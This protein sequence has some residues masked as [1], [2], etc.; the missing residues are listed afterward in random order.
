MK[1]ADQQAEQIAD[2]AATKAYNLTRA[3]KRYPMSSLYDDVYQLMLETHLPNSGI[4]E[5][6]VENAVHRAEAKID[7]PAAGPND[8]WLINEILQLKHLA[9][10][11]AA[12]PQRRGSREE[13]LQNEIKQMY[14]TSP[15]EAG[16]L[17]GKGKNGMDLYDTGSGLYYEDGT[18]PSGEDSAGE[19]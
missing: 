5:Q 4:N 10:S 19:F 2:D 16:N 14:P 7:T 1:N 12:G 15:N 13:S 3:A 8:S 11:G 6:M 9:T 17:I 18:H